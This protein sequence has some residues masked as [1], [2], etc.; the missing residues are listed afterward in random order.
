MMSELGRKRK[1]ALLDDLHDGRTGCTRTNYMTNRGSVEVEMLMV[2][3]CVII[4]ACVYCLS[5]RAGA[6]TI[7]KRL[8]TKPKLG[9][10]ISKSRE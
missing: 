5:E 9:S 1:A 6:G 8:C 10:S 2:V 7:Y 3:G 4:Y